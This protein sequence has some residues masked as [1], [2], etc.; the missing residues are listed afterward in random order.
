MQAEKTR[1]AAINDLFEDVYAAHNL[2]TPASNR[3][4]HTGD[5]Q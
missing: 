1:K 5:T 4:N 3:A 2:P